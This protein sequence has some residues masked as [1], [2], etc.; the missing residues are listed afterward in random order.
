MTAT[1]SLTLHRDK[2]EVA[3]LTECPTCGQPLLDHN[4]VE[5]VEHAQREIEKKMESRMSRAP[6]IFGG[7]PG[8]MVRR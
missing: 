3:K 6:W 8:V 7:G 2:R 1:E 4:A 5:R